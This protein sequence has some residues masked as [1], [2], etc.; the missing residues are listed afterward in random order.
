MRPVVVLWLFSAVWTLYATSSEVQAQIQG[1]DLILAGMSQRR[2]ERRTLLLANATSY[3][4]R[5][6]IAI[7]INAIL[8]RQTCNHCSW[9]LILHQRRMVDAVLANLAPEISVVLHRG[10]SSGKTIWDY[11]LYVVNDENDFIYQEF[12]F[13]DNMI[14]REFSFVVVVTANQTQETIEETVGKIIVACFRHPVINVVVVAQSVD[15]TV[16]VYAY[17][18]FKRGCTNGLTIQR[19]GHFDAI[20]GQPLEKFSDLYPVRRATLNGCPLIVSANHLPPYFIYKREHE[21]LLDDREIPPQDVAG[22]DWEVL[23]LLAKALNFQIKLR[24][25]NEPS[26]IFGEGNV[27]GCFAQLA[28]GRAQMAIGGMSGSDRR[29]WFFSKSAVYHQSPFVMVVRQDRF[30]GRM[31]ALLLPFRGKVW[32]VII[33][34]LVAA[35]VVTLG[36]SSRMRLQHA[37]ENLV[38]VSLGNPMPTQRVPRISFLRYLLASWLLLTLVLRCAYQARLF[39]VLRLQ[40]WHPLPQDITG[41]VSGNYTLVSNVYHDFYPHGLTRPIKGSFE[42][43]FER[44]QLSGP[45]ERLTT[46]SLASSLAYWNHKHRNSSRLTF[47]RK[48]IYTYQLVLYLPRRSFLKPAIDRKIKQLQAAGVIAQ[49]ERRYLRYLNSVD[50]ARN[51]NQL[52]RITNKIL[53]GAY[54]LNY[55]VISMAMLVF[56]LERISLK[57]QRLR[58]YMDWLHAL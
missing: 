6:F 26:E 24:I 7:R 43:R 16:S 10:S 14:E 37:L 33:A 58:R 53:G 27:T 51:R 15:G 42:E 22:I 11:N 39:D 9:Q 18:L 32:L 36:L 8:I 54:R 12:S 35:L 49:I 41:L 55:I 5:T 13:P 50:I 3:L 57:W 4:I 47:V 46:I 1:R 48:P 30:L 52:P 19:I 23:Q 31:G 17:S 56:V 44:L 28:E 40:H 38:L 25:P 45:A 20:T 21:K 29:R 34:I 2:D